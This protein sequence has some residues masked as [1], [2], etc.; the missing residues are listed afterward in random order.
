MLVYIVDVTKKAG[1]GRRIEL[2]ADMHKLLAD[3]PD[4]LPTLAVDMIVA[5]INKV[6][7]DQDEANRLQWQVVEAMAEKLQR[8]K[9]MDRTFGGDDQAD[10]STTPSP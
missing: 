3:H 9:R 7:I 2:G 1:E 10:S 4:V 5:A 6:T 8:F